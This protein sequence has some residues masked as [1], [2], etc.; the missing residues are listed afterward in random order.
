VQNQALK[1]EWWRLTNELRR[2]KESELAVFGTDAD[3][4]D[5]LQLQ[6]SVRSQEPEQPVGDIDEMMVDSIAREEEAEM[7]ALL[8]SMPPA[9]TDMEDGAGERRPESPHFSDE[10]DYDALFMEFV[11][12]QEEMAGSQN[13]EMS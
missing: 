3:I 10:D 1:L 13:M 11:S 4:E 12:Q 9:D 5:A 6:E 8:S 7:E 2:A